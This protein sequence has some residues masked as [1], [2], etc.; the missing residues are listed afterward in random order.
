MARLYCKLLVE[1]KVLSGSHMVETTGGML[2]E[3]GIKLLD[4]QLSDI[5]SQ[6]GGLLFIDEAYQ[7]NPKTSLNGRAVLDR[8][9]TE[10]EN[11]IGKLVVAFAGYAKDMEELIAHNEGLPR[12]FPYQITFDD[13]SDD[14]LLDIADSVWESKSKQAKRP[15]QLEDRSKGKYMT[16]AIRRL[17][18]GRGRTGFGNAGAVQNLVDRILTNQA[19]RLEAEARSGTLTNLFEITKADMIGPPPGDVLQKSEAWK[20]LDGMVG[21]ACVKDAVK[22]LAGLLES[23]YQLELA[24]KPTRD[25][26]LN[27]LFLGNP[28]TGQY[29]SYDTIQYTVEE[30]E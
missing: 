6:G 29:Q 9:L 20:E 3:E 7:L 4:K 1:P 28:G 21:L 27:R 24:G 26:A 5:E 10:M 13:Y 19:T 30:S 23:N 14:E 25:V 18:K 17:G 12:R 11:K 22:S 2:A 15:Y 8:L 16:V